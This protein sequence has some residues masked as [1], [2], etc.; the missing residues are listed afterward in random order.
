MKYITLVIGLLVAGC[1]TLT[2]EE[3]ALRDSV[4]GEYAARIKPF[5]GVGPLQQARWEL[6]STLIPTSDDHE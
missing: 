4:V 3:K 5:A 1:A 2:P 6:E